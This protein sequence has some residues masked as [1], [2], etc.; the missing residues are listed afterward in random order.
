[1]HQQGCIARAVYHHGRQCATVS[2]LREVIEKSWGEMEQVLLQKLVDS[3]KYRCMQV[4]E[5]KGA[6]TS[7]D[8]D[9]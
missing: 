8:N 4:V 2:A 6:S 9:S 1:M 5:T 3:I 7:D